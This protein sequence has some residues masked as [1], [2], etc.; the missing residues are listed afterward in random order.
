[1]RFDPM[2]F[3]GSRERNVEF[4][5]FLDF[6]DFKKSI[7]YKFVGY[8]LKQSFEY[9]GGGGFSISACFNTSKLC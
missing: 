7:I 9:L 8:N 3:Y 1:M 2:C 4:S 6:V 5:E